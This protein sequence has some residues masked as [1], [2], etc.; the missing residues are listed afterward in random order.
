VIM[1]YVILHFTPFA[2]NS[3]DGGDI[4]SF[5]STSH[6]PLAGVPKLGDAFESA[7]QQMNIELFFSFDV[8]LE[9]WQKAGILS[10]EMALYRKYLSAGH[11]VT[12]VT[13]GGEA[14]RDIKVPERL[15]IIPVYALTGR[16]RRYGIRVVRS[17]L[18][19][20]RLKKHI[21][22]SDVLKTNQM[23]GAWVA[24]LAKLLYGKPLVVR[25]GYEW[26]RNRYVRESQAWPK[27]LF[28][29]AV[30]SFCYRMADVILMSSTTDADFVTRTFGIDRKKILIHRNYVDTEKFS[31]GTSPA[32]LS[33]RLLYAGRL[34]ERKNLRAVVQAL[35]GSGIGID[36]TGQGPLEKNLREL[37]ESCGVKVRF[38]GI[39]PN[40]EL[41]K[42]LVR[43]PAFIMPSFYENSPK[44]LLEAMACSRVVIGSNVEGIKEI[45]EDGI[46]GY[47]C[48]TDRDSIRRTVKK[49]FADPS[50]HE[51]IGAEAR[52][53]VVREC[54]LDTLWRRELSV[55]TGLSGK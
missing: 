7:L 54:S 3:A 45:L 16:S 34:I 33:D 36:F 38:L 4:F 24:A 26:Y 30:S 42:V 20:S 44:A 51:R 2:Y 5:W 28:A 27:K 10:R 29:Y 32:P 55:L 48:E 15:D 25:C 52:K 35:E 46:N 6:N 19:P 50:E 22:S 18:L 13:Y 1:R 47:L 31:A 8:S 37:A 17:L 39:V 43:Y 9:D 23:R 40:D 41:P 12:A 14:D 49:V 11:E 21:R 53:F